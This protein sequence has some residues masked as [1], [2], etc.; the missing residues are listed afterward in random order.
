MFGLDDIARSFSRAHRRIRRPPRRFGPGMRLSPWRMVLL[1]PAAGF[2]AAAI[3]VAIDAIALALLG[4][5]DQV[6]DNATGD[7]ADC[8]A[9]PAVADRATNDRTGAGAD[10]RAFLGL[11][12]GSKR[13]NH[14]NRNDKLSHAFTP[15]LDTKLGSSPPCILSVSLS[16]YSTR[17]IV[18]STECNRRRYGG[19]R[20]KK[21]R[22]WA[23]MAMHFD[24]QGHQQAIDFNGVCVVSAQGFEP[25]TY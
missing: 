15:L 16:I 7:R 24:V 20:S 25:W 9:A 22:E 17:R 21:C 3:A 14:Q 2:V 18:D 6:A 23:R 5:S 4:A 1:L 13:T 12:A 11:R 19:V 8:R 10:R